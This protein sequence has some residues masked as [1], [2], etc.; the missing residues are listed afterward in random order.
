M[1]TTHD[2]FTFLKSYMIAY[3]NVKTFKEFIETTK[4]IASKIAMN[5]NYC[6]DPLANKWTGKEMEMK[7]AIVSKVKGDMLEIFTEFFVQY[8]THDKDNMFGGEIGTYNCIGDEDDTGMDAYYKLT[9]G[10]TASVQ[11]KFR[12]N[13]KDR[14]FNKNVFYSLY[15][16]ADIL[17]HFNKDNEGDRLIF[18]TNNK[19]GKRDWQESSTSQFMKLMSIID[20]QV[21]LL[22]EEI[23]S[24]YTDGNEDFW[25]RF[26]EIE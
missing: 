26:V 7:E 3:T 22:G 6:F 14:P 8:F 12:S 18:V 24:A 23:F 25:K 9:N 1:K 20:K 19:I 13:P 15:G 21:I 16:A 10:G 4:K 11:V 5:T 2:H 17:K